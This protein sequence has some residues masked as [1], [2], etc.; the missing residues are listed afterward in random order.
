MS[1]KINNGERVCE[2]EETNQPTKNE[3][4]Y[5][6]NRVKSTNAWI[7]ITEGCN[8]FCTYCIVPYTRGR[9]RSRLPET[10]IKEAQDALNA[11]FK[12]ITRLIG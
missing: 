11:G 2:C 6:I 8:N 10:I 1:K 9:E 5:P 4:G 12:E 3:E 7:N